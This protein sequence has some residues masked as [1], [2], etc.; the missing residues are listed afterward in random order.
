MK[1][2]IG[3]IGCGNMGFSL[4]AGLHRAKRSLIVWDADAKKVNGLRKPGVEIAKS[5]VDLVQKTPHII[6]AVKPQ[7]M[8]DVLG[9][10]RPYLRRSSLVVSIAAGMPTRWIEK[11]LGRDVHVVRAMP[12]LPAQNFKGATAVCAGSKADRFHL[13]AVT[14]W[15]RA[16]GVV[17]TVPESQMN[18][19]TAV[20]GSGPAYFF[21]L[22]EQMIEAGVKLGLSRKTAVQ[23]TVG[24]AVGA[25]KLAAC[26][27]ED[28][29][30]LRARVTSKGG[31][32][33]AALRLFEKKKLRNVIQAGVLAAARRAKELSR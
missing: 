31:T 30:A 29:A 2:P 3:I 6:L 16:V 4:L 7:Q 28:P 24:T 15:F 21:Y 23:L 10:I 33:E 25:G 17:V 18:A 1:P 5:N 19:V 9:E 8:A 11:R 22:M 32:T 13:A 14:A 26:S 20:S 12:N 27:G